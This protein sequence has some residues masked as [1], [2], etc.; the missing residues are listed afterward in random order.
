MIGATGPNSQETFDKQKK[1]LKHMLRSYDVSP[2]RTHVGI[3]SSGNPAK[4][5][6]KL[7]QVKDQK[8][9]YSQID[10]ISLQKS[11]RDGVLAALNIAYNDMFT[12]VN[13]ARL[14][15]KKSLVVFVNDKLDA[16]ED[17]L[18]AVGEKLKESGVNVIVVGLSGKVDERQTKL[19]APLYDVF[20]FPPQLDELDMSVYPITQAVYPG[21]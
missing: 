9:L 16:D 10:Q 3:I 11:D 7:G 13:G 19:I 4:I 21:E 1:I 18:K 15:F 20:F 2:D 17:A 12:K 8:A 5:D 6:V 14:G